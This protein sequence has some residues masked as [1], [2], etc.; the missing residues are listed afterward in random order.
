MTDAYKTNDKSGNDNT[1]VY[2]TPTSTGAYQASPILQEP[3]INVKSAPSPGRS[4]FCVLK[5]IN[6]PSQ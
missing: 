6:K 2:S 5:P 1:G 4:L 3:G